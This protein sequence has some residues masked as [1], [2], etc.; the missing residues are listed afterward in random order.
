M[1][2]DVDHYV[3][4]FLGGRSFFVQSD[5]VSG[6]NAGLSFWEKWPSHWGIYGDVSYVLLQDT[7][8]PRIMAKDLG[9]YSVGLKMP[10][11]SY[12]RVEAYFKLGITGLFSATEMPPW[13]TAGITFDWIDKETSP[14]VALDYG[15]VHTGWA[16]GVTQKIPS[17]LSI[18]KADKTPIEDMSPARD[19]VD[20]P[21]E[22]IAIPEKH[23]YKNAE[24]SE[25]LTML[26][27]L[28]SKVSYV[29]LNNSWAKVDIYAMS[30]LEAMDPTEYKQF[31]PKKMV[32]KRDVA[33]IFERVLQ[34]FEYSGDVMD[35]LSP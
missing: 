29:D 2:S 28:L 24:K 33:I 26:D 19:K 27:K 1:A 6:L 3:T 11:D 23:V 32:F 13:I 35:V 5:S 16:I 14:Y 9:L 4:L 17:F 20:P 15:D 34:L 31:S 7:R 22:Q 18:Q 25:L 21:L 10:F 8:M 30:M 12:D